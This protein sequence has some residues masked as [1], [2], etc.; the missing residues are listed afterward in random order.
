MKMFVGAIAVVASALAGAL[1]LF[2]E[3]YQK[4]RLVGAF[5]FG[6]NAR[7]CFSLYRDILKDADTA[8]VAGSYVWT[9]DLERRV[10]GARIDPKYDLWPEILH[11]TVKAKN[12]FGAYGDV[13]IECP[14]QDGRVDRAST[15]RHQLGR[16]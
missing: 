7:Q 5:T 14:L 6:T 12:S 3:P 1:M 15:L 2:G 13:V 8:Y 11:V 4:D 16:F 10:S 9:K